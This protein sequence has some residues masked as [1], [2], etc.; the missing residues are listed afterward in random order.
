MLVHLDR[1]QVKFEGQVRAILLGLG[2]S[3]VGKP[4]TTL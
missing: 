1:I 2:K 3:A 4:V